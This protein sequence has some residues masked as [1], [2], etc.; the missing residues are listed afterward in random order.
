MMSTNYNHVTG[1]VVLNGSGPLIKL[2]MGAV[3][4]AFTLSGTVSGEGGVQVG[5]LGNYERNL[6]RLYGHNTYAGSTVVTE[7]GLN[8]VMAAWPDSIP[9]YSKTFVTNGYVA[10]RV[11]MAADGTTP[12]WAA[13]DLWDVMNGVNFAKEGHMSID[14]EECE[15]ATYE[16]SVADIAAKAKEA[17]A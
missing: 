4:A 2:A 5:N 14:A 12:R 13:A 3:N 6:L 9:D 11:G 8:G 17:L 15:N 10:A 1:D 16:M 7:K